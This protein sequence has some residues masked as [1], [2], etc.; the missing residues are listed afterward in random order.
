MHKNAIKNFGGSKIVRL[1]PKIWLFLGKKNCAP[2]CA[3]F[4]Q[5]M[6]AFEFRIISNSGE[7]YSKGAQFLL[8]NRLIFF[9]YTTIIEGRQKRNNRW[10]Q[11]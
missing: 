10:R 6:C 3:V 8:R 11:P 9:L 5:I 1:L 2:F 4:G 7:N